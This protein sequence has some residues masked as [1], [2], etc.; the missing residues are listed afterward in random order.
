MSEVF[1][2]HWGWGYVAWPQPEVAA[3]SYHGSSWPAPME[4]SRTWW[5]LL[6]KVFLGPLAKA[7]QSDI[8]APRHGLSETDVIGYIWAATSQVPTVCQSP[9]FIPWNFM[10]GF[11]SPDCLKTRATELYSH[12]CVS[13]LA[14][15]KDSVT[16]G[17]VFYLY[18]QFSYTMYSLWPCCVFWAPYDVCEIICRYKQTKGPND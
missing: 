17:C 1:Q 10:Q 18:P 7:N 11:S 9:S 2:V 14:A 4:P 5:E 12:S 8:C 3:D 13:V 16:L 6:G 15:G